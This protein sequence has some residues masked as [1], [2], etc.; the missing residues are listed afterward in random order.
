MDARFV[1]L[2]IFHARC[3]LRSALFPVLVALLALLASPAYAGINTWTA[4]GP[5][6]SASCNGPSWA[7]VASCG[8]SW[9]RSNVACGFMGAGYTSSYR[10]T[11]DATSEHNWI[12]GAY[13]T[14]L[15]GNFG[16][17]YQFTNSC[18]SIG[19]AFNGSIGVCAE[20]C[21]MGTT[22]PLTG[23]CIP[24]PDCSSFEGQQVDRFFAG[25][26]LVGAQCAAP[27]GEEVDGC[28]ALVANPTGGRCADGLCF[29]RLEFTGDQCGAEPDIT[30]EV[31]TDQPGSNNC[32]SG[33]GV[34]VCAPV[35]NMNC[36]TVNGQSVC[37]D[38]V[39]EGNCA[40]LGNGGMVCGSSA[41]APPAPTDE[42]GMTPATPDGSFTASGDGESERDFD[43]FG[44]GTVATSGTAVGPAPGSGGT[45][46]EGEEG[47]E[48]CMELGSCPGVLPDLS[49]ATSFGEATSAFLAGVQAVPLVAAASSIGGS[50][51]AGE[52]PAPSTTLDFIGDVEI[53][54]DAHCG[55][56][57]E[58][59][60]V[61]TTIMLGIWVF[62]GARIILSA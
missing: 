13:C 1:V 30:S 27:P 61:L 42:T 16:G 47:E 23:D 56:W 59:A 55:L 6:A 43:Y 60:V 22:D 62:S 26:S 44:P 12:T 19:R 20:P 57:D 10:D 38:S 54:L 37:L 33:G 14:L 50:M 52:C 36:G 39:P 17:V 11:S 53:T 58:I 18:A 51:P 35:A 49:E 46:G 31:L 7:T 41:S 24:P 9:V 28:E 32:L 3:A 15:P 48:P 34:T 5:Y 45:E 40:F 4:T 25:S 21:V 29:A 2:V 8:E